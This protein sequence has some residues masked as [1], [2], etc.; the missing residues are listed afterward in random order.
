MTIIIFV[1]IET[2][3]LHSTLKRHTSSSKPEQSSHVVNQASVEYGIMI[4]DLIS[5][6]ESNKECLK[7]MLKAFY[8]MAQYEGEKVFT[9][10]VQS[11]EY[12]NTTSV[13]SFFQLLAPYIKSPDCF[14]L[15]GLVSAAKCKE[16]MDRLDKYLDVSMNRRLAKGLSTVTADFSQNEA[17]TPE[18]LLPSSKPVANHEPVRVTTAVAINDI[19]WGML[20]RIQSLICG[21]FRIPPFSLQYSCVESGLVT[22][23]WNT[24]KKIASHMQSVVLDDGD[25]K[26][27]LKENI[28]NIQVGMECIFT[29]GIIMVSLLYIYFQM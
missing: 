10:I 2:A 4:N 19:N 15:K 26:L 27:L 22:I 29:T 12:E 18:A 6:L 20:Q 25:Q 28:A 23:E 11:T 9:N 16:A 14:L 24:S 21:I 3:K 5:L 8:H 13:Q 7:N 1:E 17:A